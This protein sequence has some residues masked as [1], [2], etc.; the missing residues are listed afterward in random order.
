MQIGVPNGPVAEGAG[1]VGQFGVHGVQ[2]QRDWPCLTQVEINAVLAHY[3][4]VPTPVSPVW[5]SMRPFSAAVK[6]IDESSTGFLIKRHHASLRSVAALHEEHAFMH[7]LAHAGVP[8]CLPL[9]TQTG[10]TAWGNDCWTYEVFPLA[11]GHDLYRDVMSWQPY[12][13]A[14][15]AY[16]AGQALA[17]VHDTASQYTAPP[18][19]KTPCTPPQKSANLPATPATPATPA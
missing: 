14:A 18:R 5:N 13:T 4:S 16:A 10:A 9:T 17:K 8:V 19:G 15:H 7:H 1:A 3:P 12:Q 6:I 11:P 2:T